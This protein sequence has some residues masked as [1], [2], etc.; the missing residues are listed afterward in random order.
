MPIVT[1]QN[2]TANGMEQGPAA[3]APTTQHSLSPMNTEIRHG[4]EVDQ[5]YMELLANNFFLYFDDKRHH[6]NGNPITPEE[7]QQKYDY[8]Q[9][10][11]DW[12]IMRDRQKTVSAAIV[13][14]LN[15]GVD[16]PDVVKTHPCAKTEAW[17]DPVG[18]N[19][20]K[21]ALEAI[22]KNL[23]TQYETLSLRTR[24]KQ[25]LD[26]CVEDVKRFCNS[27][28]RN[29]RD[30][31]ILFHYNGHG[32]P[33]PTQ[34]G[35]IWVFNRGYTQYI[36]VSLYDLQTWLGAPCI[37]VYDC[38]SAGNIVTN[39]KKFVQKRIDDDNEGNHDNLAPSPTSA[40]IDCIQLAA[41]RSNE[42][43]PMDPDLPADLFTCCLTCP[44]ETSIKWF[45]MQSPIKKSYYGPLLDI[46]K[47]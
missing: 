43:L 36:P 6:T 44:I 39:F 8:Y 13:L 45:I 20:S 30:E 9:P 1:N 2:G 26:P 14:C 28:R 5:Q 22:G 37:Y 35:E 31:R 18:F 3:G 25:S 21:K 4:F 27:L 40:Y 15:I 19:E 47:K 29:A 10:I 7:K 42:L 23:Q 38:N 12:K 17:I 24:Y 33:Q 32:V 16:P 41:C 11:A 34:S 46:A